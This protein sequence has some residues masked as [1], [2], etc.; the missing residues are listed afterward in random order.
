M[1]NINLIR[2]YKQTINMKKKRKKPNN[3]SKI[4]INHD[5]SILQYRIHGEANG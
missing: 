3:G 5:T 1:N 2:K 4:Q